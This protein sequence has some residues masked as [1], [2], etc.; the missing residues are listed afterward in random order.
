MWL[1]F[2]QVITRINYGQNV[3]ISG[4]AGAVSLAGSDSGLWSVEG[5]NWQI[6]AGLIRHSNVSLH[7]HEE[8]TSVSY[9]GDL[10]ELNSTKGNSY[11]CDITVVATSLDEIKISFAPPISIPK[12]KMQHTHATFVRGL[13][14]PVRIQSN[15]FFPLAWVKHLMGLLILL[16]LWSLM[17]KTS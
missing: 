8:I 15:F 2:L 11:S 1:P 14:D 12:R 10:Y 7:L 6:A 13:L 16:A 5:G 9:A 17:I 4:L 3:A